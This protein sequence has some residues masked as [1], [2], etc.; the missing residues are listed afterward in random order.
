[1]PECPLLNFELCNA[2]L[3]L[4]I[5]GYFHGSV[6][7]TFK[8]KDFMKGLSFTFYPHFVL[9]IVVQTFLTTPPLSTISIILQNASIRRPNLGSAMRTIHSILNSGVREI[10]TILRYSF[11]SVED[12]WVHLASPC[13]PWLAQQRLLLLRTDVAKFFQP[14]IDCVV[15]AIMDQKQ[16]SRKEL[17]VSR[18]AC[19]T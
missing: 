17:S 3:T 11:R 8:A 9:R 7:V 18:F 4:H 14:S 16:S 1:M 2:I 6:F 12:C 15:E 19:I 5:L 13:L 10:T